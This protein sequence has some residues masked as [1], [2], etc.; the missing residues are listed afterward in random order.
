MPKTVEVTCAYC[1]KTVHKPLGEY[2]RSLQKER[3]FYCDIRCCG[4]DREGLTK[5]PARLIPCKWCQEIFKSKRVHGKYIEFCCRSCASAGSV[6]EARKNIRVNIEKLSEI[7][8]TAK[9]LKNREMWKYV[10]L[11]KKL[12]NTPHEFEF[13]LKIYVYDLCIYDQKL[14]V[15]FDGPDHNYEW[16]KETDRKKDAFAVANGYLVK[17]IPVER[18]KIIPYDALDGVLCK[19]VVQD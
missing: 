3:K 16:Q 2:K 19:Y 17:R 14:L 7:E 4:Q 10:E 11:E 18:A 5:F 15:E 8:S 6:T 9:S 13:P 12:E 1:G